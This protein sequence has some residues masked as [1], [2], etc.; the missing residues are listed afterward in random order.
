METPREGR[1]ASKEQMNGKMEKKL[2]NLGKH[3]DKPLDQP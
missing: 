1:I 2:P 3:I